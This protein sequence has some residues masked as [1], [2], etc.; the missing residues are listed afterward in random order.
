[1]VATA[2]SCWIILVEC[3]LLFKPYNQLA[4]HSHNNDSNNNNNCLG[5]YG[6]HFTGGCLH[7]RRHHCLI[8]I[9]IFINFC[10]ASDLIMVIVRF[11]VSTA[12]FATCP[13]NL[14]A[15]SRGIK[16]DESASLMEDR[17]AVHEMAEHRPAERVM[18]A[19]HVN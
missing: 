17:C 7:V 19:N 1:M 12:S 3:R 18:G 16:L 5:R 4:R 14:T 9:H 15:C 6:K 10:I 2:T 11:P 13:S 8:Y